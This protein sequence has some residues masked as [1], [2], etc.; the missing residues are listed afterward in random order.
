VSALAHALR[1]VLDDRGLAE[2]LVAAGSARADQFA[3]SALADRYVEIYRSLRR[4]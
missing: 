2:R 4:P 3:M 1:R